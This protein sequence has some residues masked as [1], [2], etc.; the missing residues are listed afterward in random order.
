[1]YTR[2]MTVREFQGFSADSSGTLLSPDLISSVT[3]E[4][5]AEV[6]ERQQPP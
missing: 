1:M 5:M 2:G 6:T 4:V 3:G